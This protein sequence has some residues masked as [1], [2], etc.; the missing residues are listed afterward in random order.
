MC[1]NTGNSNATVEAGR[2]CGMAVVTVAGRTPVYELTA[3]DLVVRPAPFSQMVVC[4]ALQAALETCWL[5]SVRRVCKNGLTSAELTSAELTST[6][7]SSSCP[8]HS[9]S[10]L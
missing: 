6:D 4:S 5:P 7:T 3:S 10:C 2:D 1:C 8:R 9:K